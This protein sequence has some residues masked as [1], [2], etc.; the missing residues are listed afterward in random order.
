M[1]ALRPGGRPAGSG[2]GRATTAELGAG[3][4]YAE[5]LEP[6]LAGLVPVLAQAARTV[7]LPPD[8]QR[9]HHRRQPGHR[10]AGGRHPA[11]AWPRSTPPS[12]WSGRRG[13]PV[14][15]PSPTSSS[16]P[17]DRARARASSSPASGARARRVPRSSSR[18][19]VRNAMVIAVAT[20][21]R[22]GRPRPAASIRVGLGLGGSDAAA[23]PRGR[24]VGRRRRIDWDPTG[25]LDPDDLADRF[26]DLVAAAARPIDD[27]RSTA[28]ATGAT[29][30]RCW[31]AGRCAG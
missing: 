17:S 8:P 7:G 12:S 4:T 13:P 31:P 14:D 9:R 21:G 16:A 28:A 2:A 20:R 24:G 30:W 11:G 27:H 15:R 5:L 10:L 3:L 1:I 23:G 29:A 25:R 6:D 18:S 19:G 22:G 26:G